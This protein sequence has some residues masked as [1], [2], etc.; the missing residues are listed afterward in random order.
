M[1]F[2]FR[3]PSIKKRIAA[4][5]SLK[6]YV[7]H[8]LGLKAP[9]GWGW[10]TNPKKAAYNR[11]YSRTTID[12]PKAVAQGQ[13]TGK[14]ASSGCGC[15]TFLVGAT[16]AMATVVGF[17]TGS[18]AGGAL[19]LILLGGFVFVVLWSS[20]AKKR[21]AQCAIDERFADL[22]E[23]FGAEA[24]TDIIDG[25]Y[26]QGGTSEMVV[27]ALGEPEDVKEKVYKTK[28]KTT[29]FYQQIAKNRFALKIHFEDGVVVGWDEN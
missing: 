9:R 6:R 23:R 8:N 24:A 18:Y 10:V 29:Y 13:V 17:S 2:G 1:K 22:S 14:A 16:L 5:I 3:V 11:V 7:R 26:W 28:T 20:A 19:F 21:A 27:E 25:L 12:L 4:R 15:I